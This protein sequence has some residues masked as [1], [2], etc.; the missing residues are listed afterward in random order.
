M[1][2]LFVELGA[3]LSRI[4]EEMILPSTSPGICPLVT[5]S[6][7]S[8]LRTY[9]CDWPGC[10]ARLTVEA[11]DSSVTDLHLQVVRRGWRF[12]RTGRSG[13]IL[14]ECPDHEHLDPPESQV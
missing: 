13:V 2:L 7:Q 1:P 9:R 12:G 8:E 4:G 3:V 10:A 5:I 6:V 14:A 11:P